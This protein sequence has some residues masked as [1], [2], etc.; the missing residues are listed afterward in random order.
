MGEV[1]LQVNPSGKLK[2]LRLPELGEIKEIHGLS[3]CT[4]LKDRRVAE[5]QAEARA[6]LGRVGLGF[7]VDEIPIGLEFIAAYIEDAVNDV[8]IV[9]MEM[10]LSEFNQSVPP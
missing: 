5:R 2:S 1:H 4:F 6:P 3:V 10:E 9:D 7:L 8:N